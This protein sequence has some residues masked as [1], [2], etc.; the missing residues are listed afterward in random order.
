MNESQE[1]KANQD[2]IHQHKNQGSE[3]Y[4]TFWEILSTPFLL[5]WTYIT[6]LWMPLKEMMDNNFFTQEEIENFRNKCLI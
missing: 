2:K 1:Q 3:A 4:M 5:L 6:S